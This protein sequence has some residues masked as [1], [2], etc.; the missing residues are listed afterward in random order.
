LKST[1]D[2]PSAN[3]LRH[4]PHFGIGEA[5][6]SISSLYFQRDIVRPALSALAEEFVKSWHGTKW[7]YT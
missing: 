6:D 5:L 4:L 2:Q 1:P 7:E 3:A